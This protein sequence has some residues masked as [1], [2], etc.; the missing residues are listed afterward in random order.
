M[1]KIT[2][3]KKTVYGNELVYPMCDV[4]KLFCQL[5]NAKTLSTGNIRLITAAGYEIEYINNK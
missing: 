2:V 3:Q 4:A 1:K 5:A